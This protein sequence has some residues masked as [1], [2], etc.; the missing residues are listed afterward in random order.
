MLALCSMLMPPKF[1]PII[2]K[3]CQHNWSK[4]RRYPHLVSVCEL[5]IISVLSFR[6]RGHY[7]STISAANH[8]YFAMGYALH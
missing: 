8:N 5:A 4:P 3:L 2:L 6:E 1:I 7:N